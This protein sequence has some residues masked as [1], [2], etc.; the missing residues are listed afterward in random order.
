MIGA[1]I[2]GILVVMAI[3]TVLMAT[4]QAVH[5]LKPSR[6]NRERSV[7]GAGNYWLIIALN[8]FA[9]FGTYIGGVL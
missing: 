5:I 6:R 9:V 7:A 1:A 8:V 3:N 2:I 4:C